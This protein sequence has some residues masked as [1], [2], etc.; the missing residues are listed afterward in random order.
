MNLYEVIY[1][2]TEGQRTD[3][4][5][6]AFLVRSEDFLSAVEEVR[7]HEGYIV[8]NRVAYAVYEIGVD[9]TRMKEV[10]PRI[11]RGPYFARTYNYGWRSWSRKIVNAKYID[12]WEEDFRKGVE[13]GSGRE[14]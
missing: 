11:V 12:E 7:R 5:D 3:D 14:S 2:G 4:S 8:K 6:T 1:S 13:K 10:M 9:L